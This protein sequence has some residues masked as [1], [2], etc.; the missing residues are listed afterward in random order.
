MV[1]G[2]ILAGVIAGMAV[3]R[4]LPNIKRLIAGTENKLSFGSKTA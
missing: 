2:I 4:H 1:E 3:I